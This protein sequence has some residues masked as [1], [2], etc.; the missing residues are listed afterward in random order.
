MQNRIKIRRINLYTAIHLSQLSSHT[1]L[2]MLY[3][4]LLSRLHRSL[5]TNC[6]IDSIMGISFEE[7]SLKRPLGGLSVYPHLYTF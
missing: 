7:V 4:I 2:S 5:E 6:Q 1:L 3:H